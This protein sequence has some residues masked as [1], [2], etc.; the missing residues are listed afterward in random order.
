MREGKVV[1]HPAVGQASGGVSSSLFYS[2]LP[3]TLWLQVWKLRLAEGLCHQ[4][5]RTGLGGGPGASLPG[6]LYTTL[7]GGWMT[8]GDSM[9]FISF[10]KLCLRRIVVQS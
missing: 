9:V 5:G 7:Q 8:G 3:A 4:L 2:I 1:S 10:L 6:S